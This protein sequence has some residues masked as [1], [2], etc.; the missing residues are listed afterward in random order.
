M[1]GIFLLGGLFFFLRSASSWKV[2]RI[3]YR[4]RLSKISRLQ[5][6]YQLSAK[7]KG[8]QTKH[9]PTIDQVSNFY[10]LRLRAFFTFSRGSARGRERRAPS[11]TPVVF[12][13]RRTKK[14]TQSARSVL[15]YFTY[16][17]R[18]LPPLCML[19][20][21]SI[22]ARWVARW[23]ISSRFIM[24]I[25]THISYN[26][27]EKTGKARF[28]ALIQFDWRSFDQNIFSLENVFFQ[29]TTIRSWN[30]SLVLFHFLPTVHFI[31]WKVT[32]RN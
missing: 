20:V 8:R 4:P 14:K 28:H 22:L 24:K 1:R 11:A 12:L 5:A 19:L 10:L 25:F 3:S 16:H 13:T 6:S 18:Q 7:L 27:W 30:F 2:F 15:L 23:N 31:S 26:R 17:Y 9:D 29:T 21:K 32:C